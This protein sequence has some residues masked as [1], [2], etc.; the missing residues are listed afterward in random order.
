VGD[1]ASP[2]P[3][4]PSAAGEGRA[5]PRHPGWLHAGWRPAG[6]ALRVCA[7]N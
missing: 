5:R 7:T 2:A 4:A 1:V 3:A 6:G